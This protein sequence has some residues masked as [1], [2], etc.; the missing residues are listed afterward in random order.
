[1]N[2]LGIVILVLTGLVLVSCSEQ[3]K[4][5]AARP[6]EKP[7]VPYQLGTIHI[8]SLKQGWSSTGL[9][10]NPGDEATISANGQIEIGLSHPIEPKHALW[11]RVGESGSI[12]QL[13]SNQYSFTSSDS[14]E[15]YIAMSPPG[16]F[17]ANRQGD[18]AEAFS[19]MPD[20]P[21]DISVEVFL[22]PDSAKEGLNQIG[23]DPSR[24]TLSENSLKAISDAKT[25]PEGYDYLW[26]L[27]QSNVFSSFTEG[28]RKGVHAKTTDDFGI[29]KRP[30]DIPLTPDTKINFDWMYKHLP[31]MASETDPANHDYLSIAI[32]FDNGQ[33]IT[34]MWSK[35][36]EPET[37]FK[38]P[39]PDWQHRETHIVL[40]SGVS[41]LNEW[42]SHTRSIQ[43]DYAAAVGGEIPARIT[44]VWIIGVSLFGLQQA[45][46][47][48]ANAVVV[49]NGK[50]HEL[51]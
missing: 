15:L 16:L 26:Y 27:T 34:W 24:R 13:A 31:A 50:I 44:G 5:P 21:L 45:E 40:Q 6:I 19:Q 41:G 2:K 42:H 35:D 1:V 49:D 46:A 10:L 39:L 43:K 28:E 22:W 51:M 7:E 25:L 20:A 8:E 33:D 18:W 12:F 32:E 38:C 17:W 23:E 37:I 48:F 36:I 3:S 29:I 47:L 4:E 9:I 30:L 11:G 14:G